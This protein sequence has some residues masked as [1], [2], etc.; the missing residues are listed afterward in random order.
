MEF[1]FIIFILICCGLLLKKEDQ[2]NK[3]YIFLC[4]VLM[5]IAGLRGKNVSQD[6]EE[7]ALLF[8]E[9]STYSF[10]QLEP[11]FFLIRYIPFYV[12]K[13]LSLF[14]FAYAICGVLLKTIAIKKMSQHIFLS[15]LFYYV[16]FF[17]LHEMT[18]IRAGVAT[19]FILLMIKELVDKNKIAAIYMYILAILSHF[20]ACICIFIFFLNKEKIDSIKYAFIFPIGLCIYFLNID[21]LTLISHFDLGIITIKINTYKELLLQG[22]YN[23][24]KIFNVQY[25]FHI[26]TSYFF[27]FLNYQGLIK[28]K[29]TPLLIKVHIFA[30]FIYI[31]MVNLP[32]IAFRTSEL[33]FITEIILLPDLAYLMK[34]NKKAVIILCGIAIMILYLYTY[35]LELVKPYF[36]L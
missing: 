11:I 4:Y 7:Y 31:I 15:L 36:Q 2:Q 27:L 18:Q 35:H 23:T 28:N 26:L 6:Y 33:L 21:P 24:I 29:Y 16:H 22:Q 3:Y 1:Y 9:A 13:N 34:P 17:L 8:K 10:N 32:V 25:L 30:L 19:G 14:F 12:F 5:L 20:S